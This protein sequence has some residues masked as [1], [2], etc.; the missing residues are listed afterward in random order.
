MNSNSAQSRS[1]AN[2]PS[3]NSQPPFPVKRPILDSRIDTRP[4][5]LRTRLLQSALFATS[6][7]L[8]HSALAASG[9]WI[10]TS[11]TTAN[12]SDATKWQTSV[13]AGSTAGDTANLTAN[14]TANVVI[15][16][17]TA[18]TLGTLNIGDANA[19]NTYTLAAGA[20]S[21]TLNNNGSG[22]S[23]V[24]GSQSAGDTISAGFTIADNLTL[25]NNS[26]AKT[27]TIS[28][29]MTESGVRNLTKTG[30]GTVLMTSSNSSYTG[31]TTV[32]AGIL[33]LGNATSSGYTVVAGAGLAFGNAV[34]D[35]TFTTLVA[36]NSAT[37]ASGAFVG[38]DTS[39]GSRAF[40]GNL[41]DN[42]AKAVGFVKVGA[43]TLTLSGSNSFT[44][45]VK[46]N[47]GTLALTNT[48][49]LGTAGTISF[50][51]G[52]LQ[53]SANNTT[54]Y[55]SR[56][57]TAA[58]QNFSL[59]ANGQVVTLASN[60]TGATSTLSLGTSGT[61]ILTGSNSGLQGDT[62]TMGEVLG[63]GS[64][65][66]L[67]TLRIRMSSAAVQTIFASGGARTIA[68]VMSWNS[69]S[70]TF[71]V[72]GTND[73]TFTSGFT[74]TNNTKV[75]QITVNNT[76]NTTISGGI[77]ILNGTLGSSN[78][79]L[80]GSGNLTIS[81]A[82]VNGNANAAGVTYNGTGILSLSGT[83]T[84]SGATTIQNGTVS[85]GSLDYV[86]T[87]TYSNHG[88][89]SNLGV[90]TS[91]SG[92]IALGATTNTGKLIYTGN[93]ETTDRAINL[94]GTT[95]G[96]TI[97]QSGATGLLKFS[98][99]FAATGAGSK[100]L[101]LQGSTAG[102]GEIAG[103]IGDNSTSNKTSVT[104]SGTG[105]WTLSGAN[106]YTGATNVTAGT[107]NLSGTVTNSAITV[108]GSSAV[109]NETSGAVIAGTNGFTLTNGSA[110]LA[111]ANTYTGATSV[112]AG[113]LNLSGTNTNSAITVN[114]ASAVFNET[115]GA[116]IAG[117]NGFTLTNGSA[118]L[119][120][121]NTYTGLN[122]LSGGTLSVGASANLGASGTANI[123][124]NGGT[125]Q[126]TGV[127]LIS[128][129]GIGHGVSFTLGQSVGLDINNAGNTFTVDQTL[130]QGTGGLTKSGAGTLVLSTSNSFS[131]ITTVNAG[132]L[133]LS[134]ALALQNS[135]LNT[136][137][138]GMVALSSVTTP[139]LGGL[140][141]AATFNP[142]NYSSVTAL[143]LNPQTGG[144]ASYAGSLADGAAGMTLTKTGAGA[145]VLS[146]LSNTAA[147]NYTG[148][149]TIMQGTLK[150]GGTASLTGG[151][152]YGAVVSNSTSTL[153][154]ALDLSAGSLAIGGDLKVTTD[155]ATAN[156]ITLGSGQTLTSSGNV[157]IGDP[158]GLTSGG[159]TTKLTVAGVTSADGTWNVTKSGGTFR[160]GGNSSGNNR[161]VNATLDLSGLAN[162]TADLRTTPTT[163]G[164]FQIGEGAITAVGSGQTG[165]LAASSTIR[166]NAVTVQA[167]GGAT[168]VN[169]LKLGSG[170]Q[171]L[172]VNTLTVGNGQRGDDILQFNTSTGTLQVRSSNGTGGATLNI[173]NATA[174]NSA[175][176]FGSVILTGHSCDLLLN[177]LNVVNMSGAGANANV[178][179][180]CSFD[181]GALTGTTVTVGKKVSAALGVNT[182]TGN[183]N[184]GSA[185]N[186]ANS[187]TIGTLDIA[188]QQSA[189]GTIVG[190]VNITGAATTVGITNLTVASTS[191]TGG[192][193]NGALNISG[194]AVTVANGITLAGRSGTPGVVNGTMTLTGGSLSVGGDITTTGAG[195]TATTTLTLD[196]GSLNLNN[197]AIGGAGQLIT[198]LNLQTG[199][200]SN[201]S[202]IN[203]GAGLNKNSAGTLILGGSNSY[204]GGTT[205]N[206]GT[207]QLG[208]G[209]SNS[210]VVGTITNNSRLILNAGSVAQN[211]PNAISG[212]GDLV[213]TGAGTQTLTGS[214]SFTGATIVNQGRLVISGSGTL[215]ESTALTVA[216]GASYY[217]QPATLG[218]QTIA[219]LSLE[220]GSTV[221]LTW[222]NGPAN[223]SLAVTGAATAASG[224]AVYLSMAGTPL[225][226]NTYTV[227]SGSAGSTLDN[228]AYILLNPTAFTC[229]I[230]KTGSDVSL[231]PAAATPIAVAYWTGNATAGINGVW[232]A[233][234]GS[235]TSNWATTS[236][237]AVQA[238]IPTG[239]AITFPASPAVGA[240]NTRLGA[241]MS[242]ASV[243]INDT[244][245]GVS[246]NADGSTLT[247]TGSGGIAM[248][249]GV[250]ASTI[251]ANIVLGA[252]QT[253]TNHS[254][255]L[256]TVS[257]TVTNGGNALTVAGSGSVM[258]GGAIS[259]AG[260]LTLSGP[261]AL[262]LAGANAYTGATTITSGTLT[263]VGAG[264]LNG[265][266]Y[267]GAI[268]DAGAFVYASS[269]VQTL[270][271]AISGTGSLTQSGPGALTLTGS[272]TYTGPT[273]ITGGKLTIGGAGQLGGGNYAG[274]ISNAGALVYASSAAQT[275][276]GAISG[277]GSLTQ[278]SGTLILSNTNTFSG[279]VTVSAGML[280]ATKA[281]SLPSYANAGATV[282]GAAGILA[283]NAGGAGEFT[284]GNVQT[285]LGNL[286]I[287]AGGQFGIDT[288]NAGG[289]F[290]YASPVSGSLGLMKLGGGT[291]VLS[292]SSTNSGSITVNGGTVQLGGSGSATSNPL[293]LGTVSVNSG[294]T[295]DLA[296]YTLGAAKS[297]SVFGSLINSGAAA[298][299]SGTV[300]AGQFATIGGSGNITLTAALNGSS[301]FYKVGSGTLTLSG[302]S[303]SNAGSAVLQGGMLQ[304]DNTY[305]L[306][307]NLGI[308]F[309]GGGLAVGGSAAPIFSLMTLNTSATVSIGAG[310]ILSSAHLSD[311]GN[312]LTVTG[313]GSLAQTTVA[314]GNGSGGITLDPLFTGT[315]TFNQANTFT[316]ALTVKSGVAVGTASSSA[317]GAGA[318]VI[319]DTTG[320]ANVTVQADGRTFAN[321]INV[322]AGSSGTLSIVATGGATAS[323]FSG[324]IS[325]SGSLTSSGLVT[326]SNANSTFRGDLT[327]A[328]GTLKVGGSTAP[329]MPGAVTVNSAATF[330]ING[331]NE[332][333]AG[334]AGGA[335]GVVTNSGSAKIITLAGSG[336]YAYGGTIMA[337]SPANLSLTVALGS[338]G[339]QTL[340]GS[341]TYT[342]ATAVNGGK[343][344]LGSGGSLGNTTVTT[345][346]GATF[347]I[348]QTANGSS[349]ILG[350]SLVLNAGSALTMADGYT[351]SLSVSGAATLAPA[352]GVSPTLTFDIAG[353]SADSLAITGSA[354][355]GAAGAKIV[356]APSPY[357]VTAGSY[358]L[359]T[360]ASGLG[361]NISM[362]LAAPSFYVG[363]GG[364]YGVSLAGTGTTEILT[365][366]SNGLY[367]TG[368]AS[369]SWAAAGN[370]NTSVAGGVV[371]GTAPGSTADVAFGTTSPGNL[372]NTL[373]ADTTVNS[374]NFLPGSAS[375]TV[376]PG[377]TLT[378]GGGG[379]TNT[380]ANAQ[381]INAPIVLG[382]SQTWTNAGSGLLTVAG[383]VTGSGGITKSGSGTLTLSGL[384]GTAA[385]NYT[386]TTVIDQGTLLLPA[387]QTTQFTGGL[388]FG[389]AA[390][391]TNIG[392]LD[393]SNA[394]ATF[395]GPLVVQTNTTGSNTIL[396]GSGQTLTTNANVAIGLT[397]TTTSGV[398]TT[399][400]SVNGAGSWVVSSSNG[401]VQIGAGASSTRGVA[402]TLDLGGLNT[403]SA[404]LRSTG[405]SGGAFIIGS[406]GTSSQVSGGNTTLISATNTTIKA[407][408]LRIGS[409]SGASELDSLSLGAGAQIL[410][411]NTITLGAGS[412]DNALVS[413]AT[414]SGSLAIR[415]ADGSGR[416][417]LTLGGVAATS[418]FVTQTFDVSGH[419]ADL[420]LGAVKILDETANS[421]GGGSASFKFDQGSLDATSFLIGSK[422]AGTHNGSQ[423]SGAVSIGETANSTVSASLGAVTMASLTTSSTS[424]GSGLI[425]GTLNI[426]GAN[427][428]V[429]MTSLK[430]ANYTTGTSSGNVAGVV[431]I[432]N[433][434]TSIAN[435]INLANAMAG[436]GT[437]SATLNL[438]G[439]SLSVGTAG[440]SATNGIFTTVSGGSVTT[441][442]TLDGASLNMNGNAIGGAGQLIANLNFVSGT[443][444][445]VSQIN[446]GA[447]LNKTGS[448]T[449]MLAGSNSYTGG[450]TVNNGT[451]QVGDAN[452]LGTG[453]LS[454]N[455]GA[456][457]LHGN[458]IRV[459]AFSGSGG[460]VTNM[461]S[462]TSTLTTVTSGT[463]TYAGDIVNGTGSV[464]LTNSGAGTLLLSG[465]LNM[466]GLNANGGITQLT[467]SGSIGAVSVAA[468]ATLSMAA[469]SGSSCNGLDV[470][471]LTLS[472]STSTLDLWDNALIL[473]DQTGGI[474]QG[475]NLSTIQGLVNAACDNGNWDKP[476]ITSSTVIADLGAYSVLTVMVYD[477]TV[478]GVDSFE[479]VNGLSTENGGN[480]VMLKTTYLGDFDGNG[481]V[482]SADY[483]WLD[484]Y[485]GYGL[486]VGDLNGDGQVNSADYN[487]ID[488]GYGYQAYG[489]LAGG[490]AVA[491]R[492]VSATA[493]TPSDAVPE[494]GVLGLML[495]GSIGLLGFRRK[496]EGQHRA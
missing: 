171:V 348:A 3:T 380:S 390:A 492:A 361:S 151:F 401:Q 409:T 116:V 412:R 105:A 349:N 458:S 112:T 157:F 73:L 288:T 174:G 406:I 162:F 165:I 459:L 235:T 365:L 262:T 238:L 152:L 371:S 131:G 84:Y 154:G 205:I 256:L 489:V 199:M 96:G 388:T 69:T 74:A 128:I 427:T 61:L 272:N 11:A 259:G 188:D 98:S 381:T 7:A 335:G 126:V 436:S 13:V 12:W 386:G 330:D 64:D 490:G 270:S 77:G 26:S 482:N 363:T 452:A 456:L 133:T 342:G 308:T 431:N 414:T 130:N 315:A 243:A 148:L 242:V 485:Y 215:S 155:S 322:Q 483:G 161:S 106:T 463:S 319:G 417:S 461:A 47:A 217:Y 139:T 16:L 435:G 153:T 198:N 320:T 22:A 302:S 57:S 147:N 60:L 94:A 102:T 493:P 137:G 447:G 123:V 419:I 495:T 219:G 287:A 187:S 93:G 344:V 426:A 410:N 491:A 17:D 42:G 276:S 311:N 364:V 341:S 294:A 304:L 253:W 181:S 441:T 420:L 255:S 190:N 210:T 285:L 111:G 218:A 191:L 168:G 453:I 65:T 118:T 291:L 466:A 455:G 142:A 192:T 275:F 295:L 4:V 237:G 418:N 59:D 334:L 38:L 82:I 149:T 114:G 478:L 449:L 494:P 127:A 160:V 329:N 359:I 462:G 103:A 303:S 444:S 119:A 434:T 470:S 244:A 10:N 407:A 375:V 367:W 170:A 473:R 317:F 71:T 100:T 423:W 309:S 433:G 201:V 34:S 234:D 43:N 442:L 451:L 185:S 469:H 207:L 37:I 445:N 313:F 241:D 167:S 306:G 209:L 88:L 229:S 310:S 421:V 9:T 108:N 282:V 486:T 370:W 216:N 280:Q 358:T 166:S 413:F 328:S 232:A 40:A 212:P 376:N 150:I 136:D 392:T 439:G 68:N 110:T 58:G 53:W 107:L 124:F 293:G 357:G 125:L 284:A 324:V 250:P 389:S 46:I 220:N 227:L 213:K 72:T 350:G 129:S 54:D 428:T 347:G 354:T 398:Y 312:T 75:N 346:S 196:G 477:N 18:V 432:T 211:T 393:L 135:I 39:L 352:S 437:T 189:Y 411:A 369:S 179:G 379:I 457:D 169:Y 290:T 400:L 87:G 146:G 121:T 488:Y 86:T 408:T 281:G 236:G 333:V 269:A 156:T 468:G 422:S 2:H 228:A 267:S 266:A 415:A 27:L 79:T 391:S 446:N 476:G 454:V 277:T 115:S 424:V 233:S 254:A 8:G 90:P 274:A 496:G 403:F 138:A 120:G 372:T 223:S 66:A 99:A 32:N 230:N 92:T 264:L 271:G 297:L 44:G 397:N 208:D 258:L 373:G 5:A 203:G 50:A 246:I 252:A 14:I 132:T 307:G 323:I 438:T 356:I 141:G 29:A 67:G 292:G 248:D 318:L 19:G 104:K 97:D 314:W 70:S 31:T 193:A 325:G 20:G 487:G 178:S 385:S 368:T 331:A 283:V 261:G 396:I 465:S 56:F 91:T 101:T 405:T 355:V 479:G 298:V 78:M 353:A 41:G 301:T 484:F 122:T 327:V 195:G 240:T 260:S 416:A 263:I 89:G 164:N 202:E 387:S 321:P 366:T 448:G 206:S 159:P 430:V 45:G 113:T 467:Q 134:H 175:T 15:T 383:S 95:G 351:T 289:T 239:V 464:V 472:G 36:N 117:T 184:L 85:V 279:P 265:G 429:G 296:G 49:A 481:I 221:G 378:I 76:G 140:N 21:L 337:S 395:G 443:L 172:N 340:S 163:G 245:N 326:F 251:G 28:G 35:S 332:A 343:L 300:T 176:R 225:M 286:T 197:H 186:L 204:T 143:T 404:D 48:D 1:A 182:Y 23:I 51:G 33:S 338:G 475:A 384:S 474:N 180:T 200:L 158:T 80:S 224:A 299:Y 173:A 109:F 273:T 305:A 345:A 480:Q 63:V 249:S 402:G 145:Q 440:V 377:N 194:G 55:S 177:Q 278:S 394:S 226:G 339:T 399:V 222:T 257:G 214:N 30:T 231:T 360:A 460:R 316:G 83:N 6:V 183:L 336:A 471:S 62:Y 374:V 25:T 362:P 382:T 425:S 52:T 247:I 450:T 24:Q 268:S 144:T 81:G